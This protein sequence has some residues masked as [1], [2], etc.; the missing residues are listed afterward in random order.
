MLFAPDSLFPP[1]VLPPVSS[2]RESRGQTVSTF[3]TS[4]SG[5]DAEVASPTEGLDETSS[6][7]AIVA[8]INTQLA[9]PSSPLRFT[10]VFSR[11]TE[12]VEGWHDQPE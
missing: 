9:M 11:A 10:P 5:S 4:G 6:A 2:T 12:Y 3:E 7:A 8:T 1:Q